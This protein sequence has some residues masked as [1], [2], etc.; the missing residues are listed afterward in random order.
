VVLRPNHR[1]TIDLGF[2]AQPRNPCSSS[3]R[4]RCRLH[5]ALP[6]LLIIRPLSTRPMSDHPWSSASGLLLLP[7]SSSLLSMPHLP[8]AHHEA[9]KHDSPH[10]TRIKVK[11]Q[12]LSRFKFKPRQVN[13][14]SQSN[15]GTD[16][17][18]CH[19]DNVKVGHCLINWQV[20]TRPK[21]LGGLGIKDLEKFSRAL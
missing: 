9:S 14:S 21:H 4:A 6:D 12:K 16:H 19:V 13:Y 17:L 5:T 3:P 20:C 15:Q 7:R 18:V 1:Q 8:P 10:E 11:Q 2:E